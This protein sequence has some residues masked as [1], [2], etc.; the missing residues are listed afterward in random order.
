[1]DLADPSHPSSSPLILEMSRSAGCEAT[2]QRAL[3]RTMAGFD[4]SRATGDRESQREWHNG[5]SYHS[6]HATVWPGRYGASV[7]E[8]LG[9]W[10]PSR[11]C[12]A[13]GE[14]VWALG[15]TGERELTLVNLAVSP[16]SPC[17]PCTLGVIC[18]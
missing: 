12:W 17:S 2:G 4:A 10:V 16:F 18:T 3:I 14:K 9:T 7:P 6:L 15:Q 1:M 11:H 13:L 8:Y 5:L